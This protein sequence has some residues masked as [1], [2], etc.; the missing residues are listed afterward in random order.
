MTEEIYCTE[1]KMSF[2]DKLPQKDGAINILLYYSKATQ[3]RTRK[4]LDICGLWQ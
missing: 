4:Y 1:K 3:L 2:R